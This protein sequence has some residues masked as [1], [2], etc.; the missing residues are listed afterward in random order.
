MSIY[1]VKKRRGTWVIC[2]DEDA[3]MLFDSYEEAVDLA[4]TAVRI[5]ADSNEV[6]RRW[7]ESVCGPQCT[8]H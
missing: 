6:R 5:M 3:V 4:Q 1:V 2:S 7:K 8:R